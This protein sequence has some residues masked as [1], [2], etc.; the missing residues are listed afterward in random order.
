MNSDEINSE[1]LP[2][3]G[4]RV[5][6]ELEFTVGLNV[7]EQIRAWL[8]ELLAPLHLHGS[9]LNRLLASMQEFSSCA[10]QSGPRHVHLAILV[11]QELG[12]VGNTWGFF[13]LEKIDNS[14]AAPSLPA[15]MV[16]LYL[17]MEGQQIAK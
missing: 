7:E 2:R 13:C 15:H 10:L 14:D 5:L 17:Y 6:G 12:L 9:F 16:A 4:W 3:T 8:M 11:Q 1:A